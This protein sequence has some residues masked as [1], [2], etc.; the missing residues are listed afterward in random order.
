MATQEDKALVTQPRSQVRHGSDMSPVV[1]GYLESQEVSLDNFYVMNGKRVPSA[2]VIKTIAKMVPDL[3][4]KIVECGKDDKKAWCRVKAWR[5]DEQH[6]I[7]MR[8]AEVIHVFEHILRESIF[9]AIENGI[10]VPTGK[11]VQRYNKSV[12]EVEKVIPAYDVGEGGW[13]VLTNINVQMQLMR[14]HLKKITFAE[15]DAHTKATIRAMKD[16]IDFEGR[17]DPVDHGDGS[18][19]TEQPETNKT[20]PVKPPTKLAPAP[21]GLGEIHK[22]IQDTIQICCDLEPE[23]N[24]QAF[25]KV[26]VNE[27]NLKVK[28]LTELSLQDSSELLSRLIAK[29]KEIRKEIEDSL[30]EQDDGD[31]VEDSEEGYIN[32]EGDEVGE[33]GNAD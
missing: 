8:E 22:K 18:E 26:Y 14:N 28:K 10:T 33:D 11:M 30:T 15:R 25:V 13:P 3:S 23:F 4:V 31:L 12:K 24:W 21:D 27:R 32:V 6:P 7:I 29:E 20:T 2:R 19:M 17:G 1:R 16:I 9:D 5:G